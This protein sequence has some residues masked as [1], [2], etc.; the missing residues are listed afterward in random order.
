MKIGFDLDKVFINTPPFVP[1]T[2]ID[3]LYKKRANG[4]LLYRIPNKYEQRFR[5]LTHIPLLRPPIKENIHA[6][7]HMTTKNNYL[8]LISSRFSFLEKI[9]DELIK[10]NSF[11]NLFTKMYFNYKDEQPHVFK[12]RI[13]KSLHLDKYIDDDF[14]LIS[15]VAKR[16]PETKFFWYNKHTPSKRISENLYAISKLEEAITHE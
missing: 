15:Y 7:Q 10:K 8:Y 16:N 13:I 4:V 3:K 14:Q 11:T 12:D 6:L 2:L 5:Q 1:S 9:T